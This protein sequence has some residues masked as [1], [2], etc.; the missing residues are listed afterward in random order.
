MRKTIIKPLKLL[1][2]SLGLLPWYYRWHA[3][4]QYQKKNK[5]IS[6]TDST[7]YYSSRYGMYFFY[8]TDKE[9]GK[10]FAN[11]TLSL[12]QFKQAQDYLDNLDSQTLTR[13]KASLD[14]NLDILA[15]DIPFVKKLMEGMVQVLPKPYDIYTLALVNMAPM[16]VDW[17]HYQSCSAIGFK[18]NGMCILGQNQD[19]GLINHSAPAFILRDEGPAM[20]VHV[21]PATAWFGPGVNEYGFAYGGA[22]V[23]VNNK[24]S[25]IESIGLGTTFCGVF[26]TSQIKNVDEALHL[27]R[28]NKHCWLPNRD[29]ANLIL[30]DQQSIMTR[31][32]ITNKI[33]CEEQKSQGNFFVSTNHFQCPEME[34]LN[35]L[36]NKACQLMHQ[37][38]KARESAARAAVAKT[39]FDI[40]SLRKLLRHTY[41][42]GAWCRSAKPPDVGW[43]AASYIV[44]FKRAT[45]ESWN[46]MS[47]ENPNHKLFDLSY[48]FNR[49][50]PRS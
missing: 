41:G 38:S 46:G 49:Q 11:A 19:I 40:N 31:V 7:P 35:L 10:Q 21:N 1:A 3:I 4:N 26:L 18:D 8:G 33:F 42:Q 28:N 36:E 9:I 12:Q 30:M 17:A 15:L 5:L 48:L 20:L 6:I 43:T 22:S 14:Q 29:G 37:N 13:L 47:F 16:Y 45:F 39:N 32:E 27:L 44:D 25:T 50:F 24:S 23:S 2:E 34:I